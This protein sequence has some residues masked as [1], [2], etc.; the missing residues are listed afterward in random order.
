MRGQP[1]L[2]STKP[3]AV[4]TA[5]PRGRNACAAAKKGGK[6]AKW[7][8][9]APATLKEPS[10]APALQGDDELPGTRAAREGEPASGRPVPEDAEAGTLDP[11]PVVSRGRIFTSCALTA[12]GMTGLGWI[13]RRV[14]ED[15]GP[16]VVT[17]SPDVVR[18]VASVPQV[19]AAPDRA[20]HR[21]SL[22]FQ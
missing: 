14:A 11:L 6:R 17:F 5:T 16:A 8:P 3:R 2:I 18:E 7:V 10:S 13:A 4:V 21:P 12:V 9:D 1:A 15:V 19:G 22:S 20:G